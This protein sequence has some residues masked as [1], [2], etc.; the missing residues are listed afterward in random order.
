[1]FNPSWFWRQMLPAVVVIVA[2]SEC[3]A[4][5]EAGPDAAIQPQPTL[6][7]PRRLVPGT[8]QVE[9]SPAV[10]NQP[11]STLLD[12]AIPGRPKLSY[13][14]ML[15][16][17]PSDCHSVLCSRGDIPMD[18]L[19]PE[20]WADPKSYN[21]P[22]I[23]KPKGEER[24]TKENEL[25]DIATLVSIGPLLTYPTYIPSGEQYVIAKKY[26]L[27]NVDLTIRAGRPRSEGC[28][29]VFLRRQAGRQVMDHF[30]K[31]A[32]AEH[33]LVGKEVWEI[34]VS[35]PK[36]EVQNGLGRV[37]FLCAPSDDLLVLCDDLDMLS[38]LLQRIG[39]KQKDVAFPEDR[40]EW[41]ELREV[42]RTWG[43]RIIKSP[44][45]P[46][47]VDPAIDGLTFS[48]KDSA[49]QLTFRCYSSGKDTEAAYLK[50]L[51]HS[52]GD[53]KAT[54]AKFEQVR[55]GCFECSLGTSVAQSKSGFAFDVMRE[56]EW[57]FMPLF[58]LGS[59]GYK[60]W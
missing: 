55:E 5:G 32:V 15:S 34:I 46:S 12:Q 44:L 31:Y 39:K 8:S 43:L 14:E 28:T 13:R 21:G 48:P 24:P 10:T 11:Q 54:T 2:G 49:E 52:C 20:A 51:A 36:E 53:Q 33:R 50:W 17:F 9:A 57:I 23:A 25:A 16:W 3:W 35:H 38:T 59:P 45:R 60:Y 29:L 40:P 4:Q 19:W 41:Q 56:F 30:R 42:E 26:L 37:E 18:L 58:G 6:R 7:A 47:D 27:E 22:K 1:M